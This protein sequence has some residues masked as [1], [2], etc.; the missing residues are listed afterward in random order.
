MFSLLLTLNVIL[1][2][3]LYLA[4]SKLISYPTQSSLISLC[5]II[6]LNLPVMQINRPSRSFRK[7]SSIDKSIS[8]N[9]VFHQLNNSK[10]SDFSTIFEYFNLALSHYL[11]ICVPSITLINRTYSKFSGLYLSL[12]N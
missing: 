12:L 11:D 6:F 9:S 10:T 2:T 3:F 5:H 4:D 7:I 8:V 1:L